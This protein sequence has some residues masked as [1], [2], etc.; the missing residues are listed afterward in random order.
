MRPRH[1]AQIRGDKPRLRGFSQSIGAVVARNHFSPAGF[2]G[3]T[4][5]M[6]GAAEAEH[7]DRLARGGGDGDQLITPASTWRARPT[8][9]SPRRSRTGSR[10]AVR[11]SPFA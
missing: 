11:S 9:A 4:A 7:G 8:P 10:P 2:E 5:C 6:T 1:L 3:V